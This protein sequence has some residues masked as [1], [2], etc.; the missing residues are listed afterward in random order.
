MR[1]EGRKDGRTDGRTEGRKDGET[2]KHKPIVPLPVVWGT[3]KHTAMPIVAQIIHIPAA[4]YTTRTRESRAIISFESAR[5]FPT[6]SSPYSAPP[7]PNLTTFTTNASHT[8]SYFCITT[9][10]HSILRSTT[11]RRIVL[12]AA[13]C[14]TMQQT[15]IVPPH[16][17][18]NVQGERP[19]LIQP[20]S[21][22]QTTAR[23][24]VN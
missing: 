6:G 17:N 16:L 13:Q 21:S 24:G 18:G 9:I 5:Q 11:R 22:R 12:G 2:T 15:L 14:S 23:P 4:H 1:M 20:S 7:S 10:R 8:P 19:E 3:N